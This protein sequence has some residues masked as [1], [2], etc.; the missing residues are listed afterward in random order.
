[1]RLLIHGLECVAIDVPAPV[2]A[3]TAEVVLFLSR[4]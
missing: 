1:M 2:T 3:F 4:C